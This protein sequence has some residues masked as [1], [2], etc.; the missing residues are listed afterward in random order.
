M[1]LGTLNFVLNTVGS[2][3]DLAA[4]GV[5]GDYTIRRVLG[6][7]G[8]VNNLGSESASTDYF[9]WGVI[10]VSDDAVAAGAIPSPRLDNADWLAHGE[11][12]AS[13]QIRSA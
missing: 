4:L 8:Y 12:G 13:L 2:A 5:L 11:E 1:S 10:V 7:I 6:K 3:P 9:T